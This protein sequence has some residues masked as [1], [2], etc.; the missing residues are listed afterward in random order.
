MNT[1]AG[2]FNQQAPMSKTQ[3]VGRALAGFGA[4][5]QGRGGEYLS[6]IQAQDMALDEQRKKAMAQ[7]ALKVYE[8]IND[9][10]IDGAISLVDSRVKYI[11]E[12]GGDPSD[13]LEIRQMLA[14]PGRLNEARQELG[15]FVQA[16][17]ENGYLAA[18]RTPEQFTLG[19]D[20]V[21]YD[22]QGRVIARGVP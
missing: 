5:V 9:N 14:T 19:A 20:E 22:D 15:M 7:D 11:S 16:A 2:M 6:N 1:L 12:L 4:G 13:T 3:G 8:L 17:M 21:R 18:P 10:D